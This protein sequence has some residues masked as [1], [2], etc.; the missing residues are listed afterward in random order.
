MNGA[1]TDQLLGLLGS[2]KRLLAIHRLEALFGRV[3]PQ[4]GLHR[5]EA[6]ELFVTHR[7]LIIS[8]FVRNLV[9]AQ[10]ASM[11]ISTVAYVTSMGSFV[12]VF[13]LCRHFCL[14][15]PRGRGIIAVLFTYMARQ[16][17]IVCK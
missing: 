16:L 3:S 10:T 8:F 15:V 7:A 1:V 2:P 6:E 9:S 5:Q 14:A 11:E 13:T 17:I 4:V 12:L